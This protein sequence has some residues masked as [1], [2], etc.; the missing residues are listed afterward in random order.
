MNNIKPE[1]KTI[2]KV[3]KEIIINTT[4]P[5]GNTINEIQNNKNYNIDLN[6][7]NSNHELIDDHQ[8]SN[9]IIG[10]DNINGKSSYI[11]T[12]IQCLSHTIPLTNFFLNENN[13][14]R[15]IYNNISLHKPD[16]PQLS[17]TY[18]NLLENLWINNNQLKSFTPSEFIKMIKLLN[19]SF[20]KEEENDINELIIFILEQLDLELN[21]K[22]NI[23]NV[24]TDL[25]NNKNSIKS[26]F[27]KELLNNDSIIYDT[28]FGGVCE[29][30]QE[31][32]KCKEESD[33]NKKENNIIYEYR[34]INYLI[35]P[36]NEVLI[37]SKKNNI[38]DYIDIYDCL[39]FYEN[40]VILDG[41]NAKK[42][43]K[44]GKLSPYSLITTINTLQNN[45]LVL[46]S[47]DF[48]KENNIKFKIDEILDMTNFI[49]E[50]EN[51]KQLLYN[52][53][54]IICLSNNKEIHYIAFCKNTFDKKWYKYDDNKVEE[55]KKLGND[56]LNFG[57]PIALFYEKEFNF[58]MDDN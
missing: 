52:L 31:C 24:K 22:I 54:S 56:I 23:E 27:Y 47:I 12:V 45:L 21:N 5:N 17:P 36:L 2:Q 15:I 48:K 18:L 13:K 11:N 41:D 4:T 14:N 35:F 39:N 42:C 16:A 44:C 37:F 58:K 53:Y 3:T 38:N 33:L 50:K 46:L 28:F 10:L 29:I 49:K 51:N 43:E 57:F 40:P 34:N 8:E 32:Q 30:T 1:I 9:P 55:I 6:I 26:N 19:N 7:N 25:N 20:E